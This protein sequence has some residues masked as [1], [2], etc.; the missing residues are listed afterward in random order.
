MKKQYCIFAAILKG[1]KEKGLILN[2]TKSL[3]LECYADADFVDLYGVEDNQDPICVK[4]RTWY[5]ITF[6]NCP[7]LLPSI[8]DFVNM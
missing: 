6:A 7:L 2:P 4:T 1:S 3:S 8:T 5:V